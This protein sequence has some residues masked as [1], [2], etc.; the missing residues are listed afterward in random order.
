M[1]NEATL[2]ANIDGVGRVGADFW[3][4]LPG[5]HPGERYAINGRYPQS[6]WAQ[7]GIQHA[8][9]YVL[10]PGP[11]GPCST[12]RFE[13][14][15]EGLQTCEARIQIEKALA[16]PAARGKLG[17][18][19]AARCDQIL[20]E[21]TYAILRAGA[22]GMAGGAKRN[23]YWWGFVGSGW[24]ERDERLYALAAEVAGKLRGN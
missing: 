14:L 24:Q 12:V 5:K 16:D 2:A 7:L 22:S 20:D 17:A 23:P 8:T 19:L 9:T 4:V 10:G 3:D 15:R 1:I 21:R 11:D 18:E 13:L 6:G